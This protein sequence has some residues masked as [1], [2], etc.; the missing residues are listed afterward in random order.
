MNVN[1][2]FFFF[3]KIFFNLLIITNYFF[4]IIFGKTFFLFFATLITLF[5]VLTLFYTFKINKIFFYFFCLLLI[6]SLGS[7]VQSWD[8]RSIFMFNAKRIFFE[9]SFKEYLQSYGFNTHYPILYPILAATL[10]SFFTYWSEI[11]PKV[12]VLFLSL[13][14]LNNIYSEIKTKNMQLLFTFVFVLLFEY[15]ILNGD[16]DVLISI[17]FIHIVILISRILQNYALNI[18]V[19]LFLEL[20]TSTTIFLLTKPQSL[21]LYIALLI[22]LLIILFVKKIKQ[23]KNLFLLS[24]ILLSALPI[25]HWKLIN[26]NN[27]NYF[28][29]SDF[30]FSSFRNNFSSLNY[31]LKKII[32]IFDKIFVQ[33]SFMIISIFLTFILVKVYYSNTTNKIVR[34]AK[35]NLVL[36]LFFSAIQYFLALIILY[37]SLSS[38]LDL[39]TILEFTVTRY[40]VP[41]NMILMLIGFKFLNI[42]N[43]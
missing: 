9:I 37:I 28:T 23:K 39:A 3:I 17:Y 34:L 38:N 24:V 15:Q 18:N 5:F 14:P 19:Y 35:N 4:Y 33:K 32:F 27:L 42:K 41:I 10:N 20:L 2:K 7:A 11:I 1:N 21:I 13:I 6:I 36:L 25:Y 22:S 16:I 29:T 43:Q 26:I 12:S 30:D 31:F 40:I 8:A